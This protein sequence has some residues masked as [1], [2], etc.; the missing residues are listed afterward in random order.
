[1]P[2]LR[3]ELGAR[4]LTLFAIASIVGVRWIASAAHAGSGSILLWLLAAL[5]FLIPLSIA[6][7]ALTVREPGAGGMYL[8]TRR[9][10]G[11]WHGFLC[12]WVYWMGT[13][14]W[15]PGAA[16]FYMSA[17]VYTLGPRFHYLADNRVYLVVSSLA[18]IWIAL[19]SNIVGM[20]VGK[21]TENS[22]AVA[23]WSL[24]IVLGLVAWRIAARQGV[25]TSFHF[26]PELKW[27]TVNFWAS[28]AWGMSGMEVVGLMAAEI[29]DPARSIPRAA[30]R[31]SAFTTI[32]YAGATA[33]LLVVLRPEQI[34]DLNGIAQTG[35]VAGIALGLGWLSPLVAILV[36]FSAIGQFGGL[37]S[38]VSRMPMAAGVDRLIPEAFARVHPRWATPY[39]SMI[40]L[41][42]VASALLMVTQIGDTARAAYQTIVSLM[43][44]SGFLPYVYIFGSAWKLGRRL[45][46]GV[47]GAVTVI[48]ILCSVV[49]SG[50]INRV[51]LFEL[52]L[53]AGTL[54]VIAS[55]FFVYRRQT[56]GAILAAS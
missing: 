1:M 41:G 54:A 56:R 3:K 40:A 19:G 12:F 51:W 17:A 16:M 27:D 28:I 53:A 10:Y 4:D 24:A 43:V 35:E 47:G 32:F 8:W 37:G 6:I 26:L 20:K 42:L 45:S 49:P 5:L 15:F 39:V 38:A 23:S 11:P 13:A 7:A 44:I 31:S 22:G 46:A 14:F 29:R 2:E 34:S 50:D 55:A 25:A 18:A 52:K 30:W 33:A 48:A 36:L 9:D 21:W